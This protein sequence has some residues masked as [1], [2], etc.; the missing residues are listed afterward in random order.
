MKKEIQSWCRNYHTHSTF[1][2]GANTPE[3]VVREAI[4]KGF[5]ALG[6]S[7]HAYTPFDTS[8]CM[9]HESYKKYCR[10]VNR[11]RKAYEGRIQILLGLEY[12]FF[13]EED[14]GQ[15]DYL[16]GS[17]HYVLHNGKY[18]PV[19]ESP[20]HT[21]I[22]IEEFEGDPMAYAEAY[23]DTVSRVVEET[24]CDI[25]GHF[26]LIKKF[27]RDGVILIDEAHPRYVA[28]WKMALR[29]LVRKGK[30]FE[31]NT[32]PLAWRA[33]GQC[34][35]SDEILREIRALGGKVTI[36]GDVHKKEHLDRGFDLAMEKAKTL[37][38]NSLVAMSE[39]APVDLQIV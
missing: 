3:E 28:A 24:N 35:P 32:S 7:G 21:T 37:G 27:N 8:Y 30:P 16:I 33:D 34:Y 2:D 5:E 12:D 20:E 25:I 10:E 17:V 9:S 13:S 14:C 36:S 39:N 31:I 22:A 18:L 23:F 38:F 26:D 15:L 6:F 19:D 1:C 29:K 11:L 4:K